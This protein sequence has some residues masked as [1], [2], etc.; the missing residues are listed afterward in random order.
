MARA[1]F[2]SFEDL[3]TCGKTRAAA[4]VL[5]EALELPKDYAEAVVVR[6]IGNLV[7]WCLR[8][9]DSG[10]TAHL[11]DFELAGIVWPAA[12]RPGGALWGREDVSIIRKALRTAPPEGRRGFLWDRDVRQGR[13][14]VEHVADFHEHAWEI[15]RDRPHYQGTRLAEW[16]AKERGIVENDR[17]VTLPRRGRPEAAE[18]SPRSEPEVP[19]RSAGGLPGSS[20]VTR[21]PALPPSPGNQRE[22][23]ASLSLSREES[24]EGKDLPAGFESEEVAK[25]WRGI[26]RG[27][28]RGESFAVAAWL[29]QLPPDS[30]SGL[31]GGEAYRMRWQESTRDATPGEAMAPNVLPGKMLEILAPTAFADLVSDLVQQLVAQAVKYPRTYIRKSLAIRWTETLAK[32]ADE[33]QARRASQGRRFGGA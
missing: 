21:A 12:L 24:I 13:A 14:G 7:T 29:R 19:P 27:V 22:S 33:A 3:P 1:W 8:L 4:G 32:A 18:S 15:L 31:G 9:S 6:G 17:A 25:R 26:P 10:R 28:R 2:R 23:S 30:R 20:D 5:S 16:R 11:E